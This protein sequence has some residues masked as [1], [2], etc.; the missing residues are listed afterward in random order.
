MRGEPLIFLG[1]HEGQVADPVIEA[2]G[3]TRRG[4]TM[5]PEAQTPS[6]GHGMGQPSV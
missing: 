1:A 4:H 3:A 6:Q 2:A 5:A